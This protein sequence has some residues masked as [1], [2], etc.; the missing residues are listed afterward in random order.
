M[1]T[2]YDNIIGIDPDVDASGVARLNGDGIECS[3]LPFPALLEYILANRD[4]H[5]V[6]E[7]SWK[8]GH[9]WHGGRSKGKA[10]SAKLGYDVGR[11]HEVGKKIAEFLDWNNIDYTLQPP[12]VKC[13]KGKDRKITHEELMSLLE[14]SGVTCPRKVTNQEER[15]AALLA[16]DASGIAMRMKGGAVRQ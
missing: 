8:T 2:R 9:V 7:A 13:W 12:L 3:T 16:L 15:D 5:F 14:G 10:H 1:T 4:A 11:N 6:I